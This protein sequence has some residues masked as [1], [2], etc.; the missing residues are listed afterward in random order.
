M[1][2]NN[3]IFLIFFLLLAFVLFFN[4]NNVYAN[5][6]ITFKSNNGVSYTIPNFSD[7]SVTFE[8]GYIIGLFGDEIRLLILNESSPLFCL[9]GDFI[10]SYSSIKCY[11]LVDNSF[12][13]NSSLDYDG[14]GNTSTSFMK[15]SEVLYSTNDFVTSS[16]FSVVKYNKSGDNFFLPPV[17]G[18]VIPALET[19]EQIPETIV[20]TLK[21]LIPVGLV[22]L[23]V[24]LIIYL[25]KRVIYSTQ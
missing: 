12:V 25:I 22:V 13:R 21:I 23:A 10:A 18:V 5:S 15:Y 17:T 3:K 8:N 6:D 1:K 20:K 14:F 19:A 7:D 11:C 4:I 16:D 2:L 24:G 9:S